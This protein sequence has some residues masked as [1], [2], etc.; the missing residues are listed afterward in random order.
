[1]FKRKLTELELH[2][3]DLLIHYFTLKKNIK[4]LFVGFM[5]L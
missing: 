5:H 1:V 3:E 4:A 2:I